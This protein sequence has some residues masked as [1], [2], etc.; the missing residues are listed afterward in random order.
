MLKRKKGEH[1]ARLMGAIDELVSHADGEL[2]RLQARNTY[3]SARVAELERELSAKN[4]QI[5]K[6]EQRRATAGTD[7]NDFEHGFGV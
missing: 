7:L 3:L 5:R 2:V 4:R 6:L 1:H